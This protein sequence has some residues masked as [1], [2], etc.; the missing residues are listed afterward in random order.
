M[1]ALS[2]RNMNWTMYQREMDRIAWEEEYA[3]A[4]PGPPRLYW[5]VSRRAKRKTKKN[6]GWIPM[7]GVH[8]SVEEMQTMVDKW[9]WHFPDYTISFTPNL[10]FSSRGAEDDERLFVRAEALCRPKGAE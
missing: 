6:G 7:R 9:G 5:M 8:A 3:K 10:V 2:I 4:H 1:T